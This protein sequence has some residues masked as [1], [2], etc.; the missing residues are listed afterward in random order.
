MFNKILLERTFPTYFFVVKLIV[1][2]WYWNQQFYFS[3]SVLFW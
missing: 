2:L 1:A 3:L